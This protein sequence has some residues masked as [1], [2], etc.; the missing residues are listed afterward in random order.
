M[1]KLV[2]SLCL[3]FVCLS[4]FAQ[5]KDSA[6]EKYNTGD[7][8]A[9]VELYHQALQDE[10]SN[11]YLLYNLGNSY[12]KAGDPDKALVYYWRAFKVLPRDNDIRHNLSFAMKTT[13]QTFIPEDIPESVFIF[14]NYFSFEELKGFCTLF[15]WLFVI[16]FIC[17]LFFGKTGLRY[18]SAKE[19]LAVVTTARA[20]LRSGPGD[21][22]P[23]SVSVPKA[24]L[25]TVEDSKGDWYLVRVQ[26]DTSKGWVLKKFIEEI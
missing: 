15:A 22:F 21:N 26:D 13:G 7:Y 14:Y 10:P 9:A 4:A 24:H 12:F 16:L 8:L 1:R 25:L 11:P 3:C 5:T 23:V 20:E 6:A 2:L 17:Y 18:E 19:R